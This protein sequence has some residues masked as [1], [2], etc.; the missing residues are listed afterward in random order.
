MKKYIL[1]LI[2]AIVAPVSLAYASTPVLTTTGT[3][4]NNTVTVRVTGGE[5]NAPVVLF[6]NQN[7]NGQGTT[8]Q[9]TVGYT[10]MN[11]NFSGTVSTSAL[12]V[13]SLSPVYVQ[14]G[15]VQSLPV[16][17]PYSSS[18]S[19]ASSTSGGIT[20]SPDNPFFTTGQNGTVSISGGGSGTYYIASNS[21]PNST[22]ASISGNTLTIN[23]T[24]TGQTSLTVCSTAGP[25]AVLM[26]NFNMVGSAYT[27]TSTTSTGGS[28]TG[29]AGSP[30]LSSATVFVAPNGQNSIFLSG[31]TAPYSVSVTGGNGVSTT[32][33]GN[34]LYVN[35]GSTAGST[36]LNVCSSST[37]TTGALCTPLTVYV[38]GQGGVTSTTTTTTG[39]GLSFSLPIS[40]GQAVQLLLNGGSGSY[41]VQ[42]V[43]GTNINATVNGNMLTLTGLSQ[44][45]ATVNV[46]ST[47]SSSASLLPCLPLAI[48]V[49]PALTGTGGGFFFESDLSEGMSS[50]DVSELQ[51]RLK[52]LG[53]F[54]ANVTGFFG[55]ITKAAVMQYQTAN[56]IPSTGYVGPLTRAA[57]NK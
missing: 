6:Y 1:G 46:C 11:G 10:D 36:T 8:Q 35:G 51:Q 26:P 13:S 45:N 30:T 9:N 41:Y 29:A 5:I 31:G 55:S 14:V 2:L 49:T 47:G 3:G 21:N 17:W 48:N 33:I 40:S 42:P 19:T 7:L 28:V 15:G 53:Y 18:G 39:G 56:G 4:D 38:Q 37:T 23:G 25:C 12:G 16:N 43:S 52:D 44:G 24:Q 54:S 27:S 34:T 57:F 20:F 50:G 32:L 22:S